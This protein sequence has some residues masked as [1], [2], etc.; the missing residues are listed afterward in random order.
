MKKIIN[1][2][3]NDFTND[4]RVL[5]ESRTLVNNGYNVTL[6][7][8]HF[9][10]SLPKEEEIEGIKVK[11]IGVGDIKLLPLNL[12]LFWLYIVKNY[13]NEKIFHCNDLYGLPP[14]YFIKK[15]LKKDIK[16]VYDCHEHETE[17]NIY[18]GKP[19]LKKVAQICERRMIYSSNAVI[20]VS[21]SIAEEYERMYGI[22]KPSLVMNCPY[23]RKYENKDLFRKELGISKGKIIFLYQGLFKRG[24]GVENLVEIFKEI[25]KRKL[26]KDLV[27]V[28]LTYGK[29]IKELKDMIKG[30]ENI[31]WRDKAP[32][33]TYLNYV[34]SA[35]WGILLLE[36]ICKSYNFAMPNKYFDYIMADLP[37]IVSN[38]KEMSEFTNK[39]EIGYV[40]DPKN[41]EETMK[42]LTEIKPFDN[43]KY[44]DKLEIVQKKYCWEEQEK[45]LLK[46]YESF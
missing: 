44:I 10:K 16:I 23:L 28:L 4:N 42:I 25:E 5:K 31:Y 40:V 17:A 34:A 45:S 22:K 3:F 11:R 46:L 9:D 7:A 6:V 43:G 30:S 14:A 19:L 2:L 27:L 35:D 8:T 39:Y 20:A 36:N 18:I 1:L 32:V 29:D 15:F 38:L 13:K 26:N 24:R 37:V 41:R 12:I 21:E 33:N